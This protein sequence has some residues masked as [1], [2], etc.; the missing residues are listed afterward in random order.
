MIEALREPLAR[1]LQIVAIAGNHDR[2]YFM[3]TANVWLGAE[4]APG[5]ERIILRTK[6]ELVTIDAQAASA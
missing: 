2:D 5:D 4:A 1:G 3:E 6:P